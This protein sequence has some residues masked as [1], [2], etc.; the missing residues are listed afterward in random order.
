M[1]AHSCSGDLLYLLPGDHSSSSYTLLVST[2]DSKMYGL[3]LPQPC[4]WL[5]FPSASLPIAPL[6][7]ACHQPAFPSLC[8]PIALFSPAL[9]SVSLPVALLSP[10][11]WRAIK[12]IS[13]LPY[14]S[15]LI[16][17]L[18]LPCPAHTQPPTL[19]SAN[20]YYYII[21]CVNL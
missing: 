7:P 5:G 4:H 2:E 16:A 9:P 14:A 8:L 12:S 21:A 15:L 13:D 20:S 6:S 3:G 18:Y 1:K 19:L 11:L 10:A 17:L